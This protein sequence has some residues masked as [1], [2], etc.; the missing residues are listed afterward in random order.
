MTPL[1]RRP[2]T[3]KLLVQMTALCVTGSIQ[4]ICRQPSAVSGE[5][6]GIYIIAMTRYTQNALRY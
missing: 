2:L 1:V 5:E 3:C 4:A 6:H